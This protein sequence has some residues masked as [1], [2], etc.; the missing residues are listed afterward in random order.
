L[1]VGTL[2]LAVGAQAED[3]ARP[4]ASS[5]RVQQT[6]R[7][8][9]TN[10]RHNPDTLQAVPVTTVV[11]G[12]VRFV[13]EQSLSGGDR[14]AGAWRLTRVEVDG[15]TTEPPEAADEGVEGALSLGLNWLREQEG[16][17]VSGSFVDLPVVP[18]GEADPPWLTNW[19][20]WAQVGS[21]AGTDENPVRF[22]RAGTGSLA[23]PGYVLEWLGSEFRQEPCHIQRARW[24]VPAIAAQDLLTPDMAAEGVKARTYSAAQS[25]E[26]VT[27]VDPVLVY[28]E[29]SG[30]RETFWDMS[31]VK[32]P[33]LQGLTFRLRLSV[34]VQ[35][36]R[37]P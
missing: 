8:E 10:T 9:T 24:T 15:P 12:Q 17:E 29:R 6:F 16:R 14:L 31:G 27:Q 28:A 37:L 19:L 4:P 23:P 33:E 36:E 35:V 32:N 20:R 30:V 21:F 5:Y 18:L 34:Q 26:W 11:E 25:L 22:A 1:S 7:L 2:L 3:P 13:L